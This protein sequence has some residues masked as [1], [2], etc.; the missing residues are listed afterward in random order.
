MTQAEIKSLVRTLDLTFEEQYVGGAHFDV[1]LAATTRSVKY[2]QAR[3]MRKPIVTFEWL[4]ASSGARR[5]VA[6]DRYK[7]PP[8]LGCIVSITGY[9]DCAVRTQLQNLVEENGGKYSPDL[10]QDKCT[11]LIAAK[12]EGDKYEAART[13]RH[14]EIV[15]Q[16]WLEDCV[17]LQEKVTESRY[18]VVERV[19]AP[20]QVEKWVPPP[21]V[22]DDTPW[23]SHY[24]F[25]CRIFMVGYDMAERETDQAR[26]NAM[27]RE[28]F[29][30]VRQ[31]RLGAGI[32]TK[33]VDRATHIV[34][35]ESTRPEDYHRMRMMRDRCVDG[36]WLAACTEEK[37]CVPMDDYLVKESKWENMMKNISRLRRNDSGALSTRSNSSCPREEAEETMRTARSSRLNPETSAIEMTRP[38]EIVT[39]DTNPLTRENLHRTHVPETRHLASEL[40]PT[41]RVDADKQAE[42]NGPAPS[43]MPFVE[44]RIALSALLPDEEA[45]AAQTYI[46]QGGGQVV[47]SRTGREFQNADYMVC[48]SQPSRDER[49]IL[50]QMGMTKAKFVTCFWLEQCLMSGDIVPPE[51]SVAYQPLAEDPPLMSDCRISTST[52]SEFEKRAIRMMCVLVDAKYSDRLARSKCTHLLTPVAA[53]DKYDAAKKWSLPVV[54]KAWL[55]ACLKTG[56]RQD[57][58]N[59]APE[60]ETRTAA[61]AG[62]QAQARTSVE[63][64]PV[65]RKSFASQVVGRDLS[66][67]LQPSASP[68]P[69]ASKPSTPKS[70]AA[71]TPSTD[72]KMPNSART[73]KKTPLSRASS[74]Y[75]PGN[76]R[77]KTSSAR[78]GTQDQ[79]EALLSEVMEKMDGVENRPD[80]L[81]I[82][83]PSK[84]PTRQS[85]RV[86]RSRAVGGSSLQI[87]QMDKHETQ[88][89]YA[90]FKHSSPRRCSRPDGTDKLNTLFTTTTTM[91][92]N[93]PSQ[94]NIQ[95]EEWI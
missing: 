71:T 82:P 91:G 15:K 34:F 45:S 86:P 11:H 59:F 9:M 4:V 14:I 30:V 42:S 78:K 24:L 5:L 48:P 51:E 76:K 36:S 41:E 31:I 87:S 6:M 70:V 37:E 88:V 74:G 13:W 21:L 62:A 64:P 39:R 56:K 69:N 35:S 63:V 38:T 52:Y 94:G 10:V 81:P 80:E 17:R 23:D 18:E 27:Q 75:T 72:S 26:K 32:T 7:T 50:G 90:D 40:P 67:L 95:T 1:L 3:Q 60:Q 92:G 16:K 83:V 33:N 28:A 85:P 73:R 93:L 47:V 68:I 89:G 66:G 43:S 65:Q 58:S 55:E 79:N 46:S 29:D 57:E 12:P 44:R 77:Q 49:R 25:G 53:G 61:P 84:T 22:E 19:V 20:P 54:T 2:D 8:F